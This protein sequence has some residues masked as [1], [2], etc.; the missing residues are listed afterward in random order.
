MSDNEEDGTSRAKLAQIVYW[1]ER[2]LTEQRRLISDLH[3]QFDDYRNQN[4]LDKRGISNDV[5]RVKERV[6]MYATIAAVAVTLLSKFGGLLL[7][8]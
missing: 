4:E 2:E 1:A 7:R 3:H 5:S 6:A 8:Q